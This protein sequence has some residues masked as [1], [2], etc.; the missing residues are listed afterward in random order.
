MG[1]ESRKGDIG[2][3][4]GHTTA[5]MSEGQASCTAQES[6]AL[7]KVR[8]DSSARHPVRVP[9]ALRAF[10]AGRRYRGR[11]SADYT[12]FRHESEVLAPR[13]NDAVFVFGR[14]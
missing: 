14:T 12:T 10:V 5:T 9:V 4:S 11:N 13:P 6:L 7:D 2:I 1:Q 8:V 3:K